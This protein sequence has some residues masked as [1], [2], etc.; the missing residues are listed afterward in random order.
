M[1]EFDILIS[2]NLHVTKVILGSI[3]ILIPNL[4]VTKVT[5]D[6]VLIFSWMAR[7]AKQENI[8]TI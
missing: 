4:H 1:D 8:Y 5:L 3:N 7:S 6:I 2:P